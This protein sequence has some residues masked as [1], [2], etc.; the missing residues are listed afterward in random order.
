MPCVSVLLISTESSTAEPCDRISVAIVC[1]FTL[2]FVCSDACSAAVRI[3]QTSLHARAGRRTIKA[4]TTADASSG[5]RYEQTLSRAQSALSAT[6]RAASSNLTR[7]SR[8]ELRATA[9]ALVIRSWSNSCLQ[10]TRTRI[11]RE[12]N[13]IECTHVRF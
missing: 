8:S 10:S 5:N 3:N 4:V 7:C 9:C 1:P 6:K 2:V 13:R 12:C 11:V